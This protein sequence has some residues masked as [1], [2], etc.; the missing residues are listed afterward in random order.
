MTLDDLKV[1]CDECV[2]LQNRMMKAEVPFGSGKYV[3]TKTRF[4]CPVHERWFSI[5]TTVED[6][7]L[8]YCFEGKKKD[9][10]S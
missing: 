8:N 9:A 5:N 7:K 2:Y 6:V 10:I 3:E 4:Y 1:Y